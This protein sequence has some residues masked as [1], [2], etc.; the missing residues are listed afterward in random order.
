MQL[1]SGAGLIQSIVFGYVLLRKKVR[2]VR[3]AWMMSEENV[4]YV[5]KYGRKLE[6]EFCGKQT[7]FKR[8]G[9]ILYAVNVEELVTRL[10]T[11]RISYSQFEE[12][13]AKSEVYTAFSKDVGIEVY[14]V[15]AQSG[16]VKRKMVGFN[17]SGN[18]KNMMKGLG[19]YTV[20]INNNGK[21]IMFDVK[22]AI[23]NA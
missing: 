14:N 19:D 10:Q 7:V 23:Q 17:L 15:K 6:V 11:G 9:K 22:Y 13:I 8:K 21:Q 16:Q 2:Y 20:R 18:I 1:F 3:G 5:D 4:K 12:E